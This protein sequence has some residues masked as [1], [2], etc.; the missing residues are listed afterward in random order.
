MEY[1]FVRDLEGNIVVNMSMDHEAV[2]HWFNEEIRLEPTLLKKVSQAAQ[3][4]KGT[5]QQWSFVGKEYQI[6]LDD[7]EVMI[8]ANALTFD[9]DELEEGMSYY[10]LESLAFCG[11]EDFLELIVAYQRFSVGR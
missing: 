5:E 8:R 4:V 3:W 1:Q 7:Q 10:D 6:L 11:L 2:G 9:T